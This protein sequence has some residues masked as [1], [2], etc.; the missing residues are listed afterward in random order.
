[1][2]YL[3]GNCFYLLWLAVLHNTVMLLLIFIFLFII[4]EFL[5]WLFLLNL[6]TVIVSWPSLLFFFISLLVLTASFLLWILILPILL[7]FLWRFHWLFFRNLTFSFIFSRRF[8]TGLLGLGGDFLG[9]FQFDWL[10]MVDEFLDPL[11]GLLITHYSVVNNLIPIVPS[12]LSS[13]PSIT[14]TTPTTSTTIIPL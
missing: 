1:M 3:F 10:V 6:R 7:H 14:T 9:R 2:S 13:P 8:L 4:H 5:F 11:L 12:K